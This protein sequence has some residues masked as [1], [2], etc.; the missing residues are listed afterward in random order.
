MRTLS[1]NL[2]QYAAYHRDPRNRAT[3]YVGIPLIVLALAV[4]LSRPQFMAGG[5]QLSP[6]LIGAA[7]VIV[8]Y[9]ALDLGVGA[10]M[11]VL[12]G[13]ALWLGAW[14]AAQGTAPWLAVGLG[15]FVAGWA[16]QFIGH[17]LEGRKPAFVDDLIGLAIGPLF[18]LLELLFALGLY[19][20]LRD[21]IGRPYQAP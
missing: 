12:L 1:Q 8:Y 18:V 16:L 20:R 3:H 9:C 2:S 19:R 6:A 11:S 15:G 5:L 10:L 7:A 14:M 21:E 13:L 4:L 17:A